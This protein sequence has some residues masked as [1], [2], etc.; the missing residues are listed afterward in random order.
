MADATQ[1]N[2]T[3]TPLQIAKEEMMAAR[4]EGEKREVAR[5]LLK[6][7]AAAKMEIRAQDYANSSASRDASCKKAAAEDVT[8][9]RKEVSAECQ[10]RAHEVQVD[11]R[12]LFR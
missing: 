1:D 12:R 10:S 7:R 5:R 9:A 6:E 4:K 3:K 2:K 11:Q 8:S